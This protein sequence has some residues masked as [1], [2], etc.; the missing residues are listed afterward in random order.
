MTTILLAP[1]AEELV[2]RRILTEV[3]FPKNLKISLA[4][5][6]IIFTAFHLPAS[7][8]ELLNQLGAALVLSI[9]YYKTRKVEVSIIVHSIMNLFITS[10]MLWAMYK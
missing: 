8:G 4:I 1:L 2:F 7:I 6:G 10:I 5:T 9:I 3:I